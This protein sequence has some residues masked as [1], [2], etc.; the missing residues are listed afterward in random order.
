LHINTL[1]FSKMKIYNF[2]TDFHTASLTRGI[3]KPTRTLDF[4]PIIGKYF[5]LVI[6][7]Y[8]KS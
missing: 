1:I 2:D 8:G 4:S 3:V 7:P 5:G 6:H